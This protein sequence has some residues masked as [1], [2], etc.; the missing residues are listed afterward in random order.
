M[1]PKTQKLI[2][3]LKAWCDKGHVRR[4]EVAEKVGASRQAITNW[5]S[6][7]QQPTAEQVLAVQEFLEEMKEPR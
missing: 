7:R 5:F 4:T 1:P 3:A 6:G 2:D